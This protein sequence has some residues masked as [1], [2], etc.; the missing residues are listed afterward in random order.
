MIFI[1]FTPM[2]ALS[3]SCSCIA[4]HKTKLKYQIQASQ[5]NIS[6]SAVKFALGGFVYVY[7]SN[8]SIKH[9]YSVEFD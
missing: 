4:L 2:Y 7:Y 1:V 6:T 8:T 3:E 5:S 9:V